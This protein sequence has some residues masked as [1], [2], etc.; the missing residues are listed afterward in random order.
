M[1]TSG[2]RAVEV[3]CSGSTKPRSRRTNPT[4]QTPSSTSSIAGLWP[5]RTVETSTRCRLSERMAQG[6][7][8]CD[9]GAPAACRIDRQT[10]KRPQ[11]KA[12][13]SSTV[14]YAA[15]SAMRV[16]HCGCPLRGREIVRHWMK[17]QYLNA[18]VRCDILPH[19][20]A[21]PSRRRGRGPAAQRAAA[22][23]ARDAGLCGAARAADGAAAPIWKRP[24]SRPNCSV[25]SASE[26][27]DD[28]VSSAIAAFCWVA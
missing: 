3:V 23:T 8:P 26:R 24:I 15:R 9:R 11:R 19:G 12:A 13:G 7:R 25:S 27:A 2:E 16:D 28:V 17:W 1:A 22:R 21:P 10:E 20:R 5:A 6:A 4:I 14:R 18:S